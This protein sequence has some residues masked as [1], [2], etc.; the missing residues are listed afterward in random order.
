MRGEAPFASHAIYTLP[1]VLRDDDPEE[2]ALGIRAGFAYRPAV[3]ATIVYTDL[4][5]SP[6]MEAGIKD[7]ALYNRIV[8]KRSLGKDWEAKLAADPLW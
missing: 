4:G 2:R 8:E 1:G 3:E 6:G 5:I 7:A